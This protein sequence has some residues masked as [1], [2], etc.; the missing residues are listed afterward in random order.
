MP[1]HRA[2]RGAWWAVVVLLPLGFAVPSAQAQVPPPTFTIDSV[3]APESIRPDIGS[4]EV[5]IHWTYAYAVPVQ[6]AIS[7]VATAAELHWDAP[8]CT[9]DNG[10]IQINGFRTQVVPLGGGPVPQQ[11]VSGESRFHVSA[12]REAPGEVDIAC[13]VSGKVRSP[14]GTALVP[15]S[16]KATANFTAKAVFVGLLRAETPMTILEGGPQEILE[17]SIELS[18]LGNT[19]ASA[20]FE[21]AHP[22]PEG[23]QVRAPVPTVLGAPG[24]GQENVLVRL[25]VGT[26]HREGWNN[27][28]LALQLGIATG[29]TQDQTLKGNDIVVPV[30]AR[31]RGYYC[32]E[33][34]TCRALLPELRSADCRV[35][36]PECEEHARKVEE[37]L[38]RVDAKASPSG[39]LG[40]FGAVAAAV[41]LR[42]RRA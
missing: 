24:S 10:G 35:S 33:V 22:I 34:E 12:T 21:I 36:V 31:V 14:G 26:P 1:A 25:E 38:A 37:M 19:Q 5:V 16:N 9:N 11:S 41:L 2:M 32:S 8:A 42:R 20:T 40:A 27:D 15:D 30:L 29:S 7:L 23:W 6:S 28:Q 39:F 18:N 13:S 4:G 17:F 3:D